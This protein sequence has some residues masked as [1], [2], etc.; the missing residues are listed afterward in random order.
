MGN[1]HTD[2]DWDYESNR[3]YMLGID[4]FSDIF[5]Q[6]A[7]SRCFR[8]TILLRTSMKPRYSNLD[9]NT[10]FKYQLCSPASNLMKG[11]WLTKII[12]YLFH[13]ELKD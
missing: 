3:E 7:Y 6:L 8:A 4:S 12:N 5:N 10:S 9:S 1:C 2:T 13:T 11:N